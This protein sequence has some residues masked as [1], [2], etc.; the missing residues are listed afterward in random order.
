MKTITKLFIVVTLISLSL[1]ACGEDY[2][3]LGE[4]R[5]EWDEH[6]PDLHGQKLHFNVPMVY[7]VLE[8][9]HI[10]DYKKEEVEIGRVMRSE[11]SS[12]EP[13]GA[14]KKG[15]LTEP[16]AEDM[17]FTVKSSYWIR[18]DWFERE[19]NHDM[20]M[21]VLS[22]E[23]GFETIC[24]FIYVQLDSNRPELVKFEGMGRKILK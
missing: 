4:Y 6:N 16:I 20:H 10:G 1:T 11:E 2:I 23:Y 8:E 14:V 5:I 3:P 19:L 24:L 22:D 17:E 12:L 9:K 21:L 15:Y 18:R 7:V 13:G